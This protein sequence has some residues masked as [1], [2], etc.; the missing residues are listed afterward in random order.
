LRL[1]PQGCF[2]LA[3]NGTAVGYAVSHP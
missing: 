3:E 1:F 2:V